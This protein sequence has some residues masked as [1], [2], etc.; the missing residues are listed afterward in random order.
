MIL[1]CCACF[2]HCSFSFHSPAF[3]S[4][5]YVLLPAWLRLRR[6]KH[7]RR[8]HGVSPCCM[9]MWCFFVDSCVSL[10]SSNTTVVSLIFLQLSVRLFTLWTPP[11]NPS[12]SWNKPPS[13][14]GFVRGTSHANP[15]LFHTFQPK[16]KP[17][18]PQFG[19]QKFPPN[20][21]HTKKSFREKPTTYY[22]FTNYIYIR[23]QLHKSSFRNC[24]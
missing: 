20:W 16:K 21:L 18:F 1:P 24:F 5:L 4:P 15:K 23:S 22:K 9:W 12:G 14:V 2:W 6:H 8:Q 13:L 3:S 19:D 17:V 10:T 7:A 11:P